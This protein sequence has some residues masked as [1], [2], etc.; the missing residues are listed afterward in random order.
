VPQ[1]FDN[2]K[3]K[4]ELK[5]QLISKIARLKL[6][7]KLNLKL[8][9]VLIG[10]NLSSVKYVNLKKKIGAEIGV[11]VVIHK[12][13]G[14]EKDIHFQL[15][16]LLE[17]VNNSKENYEGLI[18]QLPLASEFQIYLDQVNEYS[19]IDLL[20]NKWAILLNKGILW[21]TVQAIQ[22]CL[23]EIISNKFEENIINLKGKT[24]AVVGQGV[25]VGTPVLN[26][27]TKTEATIISIN[28]DTE[29]PEQLTKQADILISGV[30]VPKLINSSWIKP[31]AILIDAGTSDVQ[32]SL[33]GDI[34]A[35]NLPEN[36]ILCPSPGGIGPITVLSLFWNVLR[37]AKIKKS[38]I[39][40][41]DLI[42]RS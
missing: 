33:Q 22:L 2:T 15:E 18:F 25:L 24:V 1:I 3:L 30:G 9:I 7:Q 41:R 6:E 13:S 19:D 17:K 37:L 31:G 35:A 10:D 26:W 38:L 32:G 8:H 20:S 29:N 5:D 42:S 12:Y 21:P 40:A 23:Y 34:D 27:L 36:S 28:K 11:E 16:K 14:E 39:S 4:S